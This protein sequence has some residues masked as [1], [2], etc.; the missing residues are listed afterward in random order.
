MTKSMNIQHQVQPMTVEAASDYAS[1]LL[2]L[3]QRGSSDTEGALYRIEQRYG[4]SPNQIMHLRSRR[5]KSCDV[6]LF[7]RIQG[8]YLDLCKRQV[9]KLQHE[10][11]MT[12]ATTD[13]ALEDLAAEAAALAAKIQARK[14]AMTRRPAAPVDG[15]ED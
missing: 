7:A 1:R 12:E 6:S 9:S 5:A 15:F 11:A 8:A 10:I 4:L 13:D 3:E 14:Q 2:D